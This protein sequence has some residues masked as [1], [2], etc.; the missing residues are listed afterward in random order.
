[1][2]RQSLSLGAALATALAIA[3]PPAALALEDRVEA[4]SCSNATNGSASGNTV[5]CNFGLTDAQLKQVTEAA[6]KGATGPLVDR[7]T[8]IS[9][10]LGVTE[11]AAKTLLKIVGE[12]ANIPDDKLGEALSKVA[13]DYKRLQAQTTA[14]N[15]DN[16]TAKVLIE[17]AKS[18][19]DTGNF[20][21]AHQLLGQATQAQIVAA[22]E[23]R[24]L[25]EQAQTAE[26]AL[27]LGAA[28]ST[29]ADG[30]LA[31]TERRYA[32][33]AEL[34][35]QAANYVPSGHASKRVSYLQ[36]QARAF[37]RQAEERGD[38]ASLTRELETLRQALTECDRE[39]NPFQWATIEDQRGN[40]LFLQGL[41]YRDT[42]SLGEAIAAFRAAEEVITRKSRPDLWATE[43]QNVGTALIELGNRDEHGTARLE[44]AV[45]TLRAAQGE[46]T[47]ESDPLQW[48][49]IEHNLGEALRSL[50]ERESDTARLDEA[51]AAFQSGLEVLAQMQ[52]R[53]DWREEWA[54]TQHSLGNILA[55]VG[56][57][58]S[59]TAKLE[60]A[61]SA[62]RASLTVLTQEAAPYTRA[63]V[64]TQLGDTLTTLSEREGGR[65][66]LVEAIAAYRAAL[67]E[68][69]REQDQVG[70]ASIQKALAG[71]L[72]RLG[73]MEGGTAHLEEA[74]AAYRIAVE[75]SSRERAPLEWAHGLVDL[76]SS[77]TLLGE[78]ERGTTRLE[79]AVAAF[80]AALGEETRERDPSNWAVTQNN[81]CRALRSLGERE[82]GTARLEEA[83]DACRAAL[84]E[85]TRDRVALGWARTQHNLGNALAALGERES[86]TGRLEEAVAAYRAALEERSRELVPQ[87]WAASTGAQ[88][89]ALIMIADR[90]NDAAVAETAVQRIKSAFETTR[91]G[92]NE[93]M[94]AQFQ[95]QLTKA[96][97]I[98]DRVMGQKGVCS[99]ATSAPNNTVNCADAADEAK[100]P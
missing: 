3:V 73:E 79:E 34:F 27:M 47:Q 48:A 52:D 87:D 86:G 67:E 83:V 43:Q 66:H 57:R 35:D 12:D 44:E 18:E 46:V 69:V 97:T 5:T 80:R 64:Q 90:T 68:R 32:G 11:D 28:S 17:Q 75:S 30:D 91:S 81:L 93:H 23:A 51:I 95:E 71:A 13:D 94:S 55:I 72:E 89:V 85:R 6:V 70:S 37:Y 92:G 21:H 53:E 40:A 78:R 20:Q 61:L 10:T 15:P 45:T 9:K 14:L 77:L 62:Y 4:G 99:V 54:I 49:I 65:T 31:M 25:R 76:G 38:K 8:D 60:D 42:G 19:I 16:L 56:K 98:R 58:E 84:Q 26:D 100:K 1:M 2:T 41:R 22:H 7:I 29:A 82:D 24:K 59:G 88:G 36:L 96:Q 63:S 74:V 39:S 33:A 50:G